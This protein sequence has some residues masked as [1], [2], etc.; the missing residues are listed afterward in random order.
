[1]IHGQCATRGR[2]RSDQVST[3]RLVPIEDKVF[4]KKE[5]YFTPPAAPSSPEPIPVP[6]PSTLPEVSR[7]EAERQV[8]EVA[9]FFEQL[10]GAPA[11]AAFTNGDWTD[12]VEGRFEEAGKGKG[13][14][15]MEVT[16][17]KAEKATEKISEMVK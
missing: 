14:E 3:K 4:L 5:G 12:Y 15:R 16:T 8:Q 7:E 13:K 17:D 2:K 1:M 10:G 9:K 6:G 11:V